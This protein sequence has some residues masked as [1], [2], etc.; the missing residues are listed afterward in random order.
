M[1]FLAFDPR[2]TQRGKTKQKKKRSPRKQ[3]RINRKK[4]KDE[5][6]MPGSVFQNVSKKPLKA[7]E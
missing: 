2:F 3:L 6:G 7:K 5:A 4:V 1:D